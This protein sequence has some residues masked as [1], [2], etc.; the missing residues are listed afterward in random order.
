MTWKA[1][2]ERLNPDLHTPPTEPDTRFWPYCL[3][4]SSSTSSSTSA[5]RAPGPPTSSSPGSSPQ[6]YPSPSQPSLADLVA[7][8]HAQDVAAALSLAEALLHP[9]AVRR[10]TPLEA[11][12]H[13]FLRDPAFEHDGLTETDT[14][15]HPFMH[16]VCK[17]LHWLDDSRRGYVYVWD[18]RRHELERN[19]KRKRTSGGREGLGRPRRRVSVYERGRDGEIE[20]VDLDVTSDEEEVELDEFGRKVLH[21][22]MWRPVL[23]GEGIATG[24]K[25]CEFHRAEQGYWFG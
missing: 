10:C 13:P 25:P 4:S 2:I 19:R 8:T 12:A 5:K 9:D 21:G 24:S 7:S 14:V 6:P 20:E 15:P 22:M 3:D 18:P 1:F 23:A 11:L 17:E 16:G